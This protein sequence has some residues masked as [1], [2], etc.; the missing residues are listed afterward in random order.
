[1]TGLQLTQGRSGLVVEEIREDATPLF[2]LSGSKM[3]VRYA[4][5][6]TGL[7]GQKT[8]GNWLFFKRK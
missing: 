5:I 2:E 6:K 1:M 3:Q 4:R 7:G 8:N